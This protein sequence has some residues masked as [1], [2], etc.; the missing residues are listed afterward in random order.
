MEYNDFIKAEWELVYERLERIV[1]TGCSI[2]LNVQV[3]L[4]FDWYSDILLFY[5][6]HIIIIIILLLY[7]Y[8][9]IIILLLYYYYIII[10][11]LSYIIVILSF[12]NFVILN[13]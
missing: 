7:Y 6:Y 10:I 8:Y 12:Y 11:L 2:V 13:I 1:A 9:I 5:Y 4:I 3:F